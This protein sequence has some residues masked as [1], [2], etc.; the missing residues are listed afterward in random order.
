[1]LQANFVVKTVNSMVD[2]GEL[3]PS[4][5]VA[6]IY[7]TNA[8]SRLLEEACVEQ[9]VRYVVRGST[10]TFYKRAEVQDC[11]CFLKIMYNSRDRSAWARAVRTPSRGIGE[12]SLD[13]FFRY[14]DAVTDKFMETPENDINPPTPMDVMLSLAP[15]GNDKPEDL[16]MYLPPKNIMST[17]SLNRFIPFARSLSLL[18]EKATVQSVPELLSSIIDDLDL[19]R[20][21]SFSFQAFSLLKTTDCSVSSQSF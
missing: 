2:S 13:E 21:V 7:R 14:C 17:R 16:G 20:Y 1:M 9:N 5:T 8:Q 10:G 4:S 15:S 19:K 11:M 6:F 12:T 3:T 18:T